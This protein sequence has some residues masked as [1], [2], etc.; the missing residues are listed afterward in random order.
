MDKEV[1]DLVSTMASVYGF[2]DAID[3]VPTK[4]QILEDTIK[5]LFIQTVECVMFI[6]EYMGRGFGGKLMD[7]LDG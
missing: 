5:K 4:V 3:A 6:R 2:V 7:R 1:V